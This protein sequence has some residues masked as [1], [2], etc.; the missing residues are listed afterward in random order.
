MIGGTFILDY[1]LYIVNKKIENNLKERR[2]FL[3]LKK[4]EDLCKKNNVTI[5]RLEKECGLG[6]ATI[7]GWGYSI[8]RADNLK[9]VADYFGVSIEYFL[10]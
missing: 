1:S 3:I 5:S 8:P 10:E 6:N 9:K 4:I 2:D 7:K